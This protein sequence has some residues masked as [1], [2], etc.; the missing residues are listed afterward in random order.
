MCRR[1][2]DRTSCS[3]SPKLPIVLPTTG[4]RKPAGEEGPEAETTVRCGGDELERSSER[5]GDRVTGGDEERDLP[6]VLQSERPT[7]SSRI[8]GAVGIDSGTQLTCAEDPTLPW[9]PRP[10]PHRSPPE[11]SWRPNS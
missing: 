11:P 2:L 6:F 1:I 5:D 8:R 7:R 10:D 4:V 9:P 3:G